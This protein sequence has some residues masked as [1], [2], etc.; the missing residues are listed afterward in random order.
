MSEKTKP[1]KCGA[2]TRAGGKCGNLPMSNGRCYLHGGKSLKGLASPSLVTG[3]HSKYLK[4]GVLDRYQEAL[5]DK[6]LLALKDDIA[7][8]DARIGELLG[9][10][11]D[12]KTNLEAFTQ[13]QDSYGAIIEALNAIPALSLTGENDTQNTFNLNTQWRRGRKETKKKALD[14]RTAINQAVEALAEMGNQL[15]AIGDQA[16]AWNQIQGLVE[17][18]R[19]LVESE[20]KWMIENQQ[21]ITAEKAML[22][23]AA[24]AD[25]IRSNVPDAQQRAS[26]LNGINTL[27]T[28]KAT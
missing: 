2:K 12:G 23:I 25:V 21:I 19:R 20:R 28:A 7:L 18:R 3:R 9:A 10:I 15:V 16:E 5:T 8:I 14:E 4:G 13:I 26:I 1:K 22:L 27:I 17:Q 11:G 24:I 6:D